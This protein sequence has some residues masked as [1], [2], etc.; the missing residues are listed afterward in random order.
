MISGMYRQ[1]IYELPPDSIRELI[2]S[3]IVHRSY[4]EQGHIQVAI[5]DNRLEITSP[6]MLPRGVA[7]DKM[8]EGYSKIRN[9][10]IASVV[11]YMKIIEQ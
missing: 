5:F 7:I 2:A 8:K 9:R 10:A 11:S 6:G 1:D 4:I 3:A